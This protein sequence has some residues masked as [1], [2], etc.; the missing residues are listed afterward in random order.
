[1]GD[2]DSTLEMDFKSFP[3]EVA[4]L[5]VHEF[6][7]PEAEAR[8]H[9][10]HR[11]DGLLELVMLHPEFF[12]RQNSGLSET[13]RRAFHTDE[14]HGIHPVNIDEFPFHR[15]AEQNMHDAAHV[16]LALRCEIEAHEP[17]LDKEGFTFFIEM[18]PHF[19]FT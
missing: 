3:I 11:S 1:M 10:A 9:D 13:F 17:F 16:P 7:C 14:T 8:R 5:Q 4:P 12:D 6:A 15:P 2:D 19:G 18:P